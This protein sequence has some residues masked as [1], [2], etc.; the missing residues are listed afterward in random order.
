MALAINCLLENNAVFALKE[1]VGEPRESS[2]T[3]KVFKIDKIFGVSFFLFRKFGPS[4]I[5]FVI[6]NRLLRPDH[7]HCLRCFHS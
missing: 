3:S 7:K 2:P 1:N 6:S 5:V 4:Q